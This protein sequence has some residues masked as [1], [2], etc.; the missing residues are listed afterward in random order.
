MLVW[1][2]LKRTLT[3]G[4]RLEDRHIDADPKCKRCGS[5]ESIN[6]L[7]VHCQYA[8]DVW[9]TALFVVGSD[10]SGLGRFW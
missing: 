10:N 7:F 8:Q 3:V 1:K 6:H 5:P 9:R 4:T 2:A